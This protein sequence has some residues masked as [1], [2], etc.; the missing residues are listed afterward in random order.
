MKAGAV[1]SV[2]LLL[3]LAGLA[4]AQ[5]WWTPLTAAVFIKAMLTLGIL[6]VVSVIVTL[7]IREYVSHR[8]LKDNDY[9]D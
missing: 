1:V 4:I 6:L 7:V 3:A 8:H 2:L 9:I 5:L